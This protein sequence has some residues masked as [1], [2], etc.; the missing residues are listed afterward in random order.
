MNRTAIETNPS[1]N[2]RYRVGWECCECEYDGHILVDGTEPEAVTNQRLLLIHQA[3]NPDC[4][5]A[6]SSVTFDLDWEELDTDGETFVSK[7]EV[8]RCPDC[9]GT[10]N[11]GGGVCGH[12]MG[13]RTRMIG[14]TGDCFGCSV[15]I[16]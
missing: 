6:S 5:G 14:P 3:S 7:L 8:G 15:T 2:R 16:G 12:C 1:I 10:G 11:A 4:A 13:I 9:N